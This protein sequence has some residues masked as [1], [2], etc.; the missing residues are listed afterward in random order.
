[1]SKVLCSKVLCPECCVQSVVSKV[2]C[3]KCFVQSVVSKVLCPKC[4]VQS[5]VSKVL[6]P[7]CC[8]QSVVSKVLCPKCFV[9]SVLSK[10]L[11]PKCCVQSVVSKVLCPKCCVQSVV[12]KSC[13]SCGGSCQSVV[14]R[15]K[16]WW[17]VSS[18][19]GSCQVGSCQV[20]S[21]CGGSIVF[22]RLCWVAEVRYV[23][24][25]FTFF[26]YVRFFVLFFHQ[27]ALVF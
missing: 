19:G 13:Q 26:N 22:F 12:T 1:M 27:I 23:F 3:P 16:L 4:C 14:G 25:C 7:K 18:F 21:S 20:V 2:L 24:C 10:V 9:Q 15:V 6:C 5:V 8:V 11:C 17:V